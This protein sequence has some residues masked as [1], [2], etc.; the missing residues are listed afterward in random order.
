MAKSLSSFQDMIQQDFLNAFQVPYVLYDC[1][2]NIQYMFLTDSLNDISLEDPAIKKLVDDIFLDEKSISKVIDTGIHGIKVRIRGNP[3]L[4]SGKLLGVFLF[5]EIPEINDYEEL[6]SLATD[7]RIIF[8]SSYD[9]IFVADENGTALRVSDSCE[10]FWGVKK[11]E[12][13]GSNVFKLEEQGVFTPSVTRM[14]LEQKRKISTI[15]KTDKNRTL[16]VVGTPVFDKSGKV[17]RIVNASRDITE[18]DQLQKELNEMKEIS[19]GY[20]REIQQ[21]KELKSSPIQSKLV[22]ESKKMQQVVHQIKKVASY[23]SNVLI[24]GESGVGKEIIA[25]MIHHF[26]YRNDQP[27]VKINCGAIPESLLESELFGYEKGTFTGGNKNGK[28]GLFFAANNGTILLDEVT[29]M[30]MP[31]QVKLL[32]VLQE[33][34]IRRVGS[35]KPIKIDVRVIASTNKNIKKLIDDKQFREDLYYRLN[36]FPIE[37]PP[38][39]D[40]KEDIP[41]IT[42]H[43]IELFNQ[44]YKTNKSISAEALRDLMKYKWEGNVRELQ[45]IIERVLIMS[46]GEV[47]E[48]DDVLDILFNKDTASDSGF[49]FDITDDVHYYETLQAIERKILEYSLEKYKSTVEMSKALHVSQSTISKKLSKFGLSL[50]NAD[51]L[52]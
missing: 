50:K 41:A 9:V 31:L 15:Q 45:N 16:L 51:P 13:I 1:D 22:Y 48:K 3:V 33:R 36:V 29:E 40:R 26:S 47:I 17:R 35:V 32:R 30:S 52:K 12:F 46:H 20:Q 39:R 25:S 7:L 21:L 4:S 18:I 44:E 2:K 5:F 38:L 24:L 6:Q 28:D 23:H 34:E 27:F 11:E 37:V 10:R 42:K 43:F 49:H 8:E 14:V 19:A